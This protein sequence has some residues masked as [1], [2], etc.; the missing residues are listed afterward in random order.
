MDGENDKDTRIP[1]D[2]LVSLFERLPGEEDVHIDDFALV[3]MRVREL[4]EAATKWQDEISRTTMLSN[5]GG[6]RRAP[7][8]I[9]GKVDQEIESSSKLQIE[10]MK[11]LAANPILSKVVMPRE[12]AVNGI[13]RT[14][15]EFESK[16][17]A[18]LSMDF[19]GPYPDRAAYPNSH[20]LVGRT[21]EFIL[22]R[23]TMGELFESVLESVNE[24]SSI[25]ENV[26]AET[27]E[28]VTFEWIKRAVSWIEQ[29]N[30]SVTD[31]SPFNA[32]D[33]KALVIPEEIG[34]V[35]LQSA[36][37]IF[38]D[39]PDDLK[40][41]LS[42]HGIFVS[43]NKQD[44]NLRVVLKKDGAHHSVGG[45]VIRWC[46]ILFECLRADLTRL[47]HFRKE[48]EV[49]FQQFTAFYSRVKDEPKDKEENLYKWFCY[50]ERASAL[51]D[52]GARSLVV[53]PKKTF[54]DAFNNLRTTFRRILDTHS[55][56]ELEKKFA[57][58]WFMEG[59][60]LLDDRF[61]L[62]ES[63]LHRKSIA[64]DQ[65]ATDL[66]PDDASPTFRDIC[67]SYLV[68]SLTEA[69]KS[70]GMTGLTEEFDPI[71]LET[72]CSMKAWEI[73]G[74]MYIK[75]QDEIGV[76]RVSEDYRSK[77][78]NLKAS[79]SDKNNIS[80][81]LRILLG[82]IS[83]TDLVKM[84][85][86]ELASQ[87]TKL[88]RARA[89][90]EFRSA[91]NLTPGIGT[92][93]LQI[94]DTDEKSDDIPNDKSSSSGKP[95]SILRHSKAGLQPGAMESWANNTLGPTDNHTPTNAA[96]M[97]VKVAQSSEK[98]LVTENSLNR[99]PDDLL[100]RLAKPRSV[101]PP[102][103]PSLVTAFQ[104]S[105]NED[106]ED[107]T[108]N[109]HQIINESGGIEFHFESA[110]LRVSFDF[111]LYL[112]NG[113]YSTIDRFLQSSL[114][115]KGRVPGKEFAKFVSQKTSGSWIAIPLR[116]KPISD[117][118]DREIF[119]LCQAYEAKDRV[120][121]ISLNTDGN[122]KLFFVIPHFHGAASKTGGVSFS[123]KTSSYVLVLTKDTRFEG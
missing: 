100:K 28:K 49:I 62:L 34:R 65:I 88:E 32:A 123:S 93:S 42:Q 67:R 96:S 5:R 22:F 77:A 105:N 12:G 90:K 21:G 2:V 69:L 116:V 4:H 25:A 91:A 118:D 95:A 1:L 61:L 79:L 72:L 59:T 103:P 58:M 98:E 68:A 48:L 94:V 75:F 78:R 51:L 107:D 74:E 83:S 27:P 119:R 53:A 120:P 121:M 35:L 106:S 81:C 31:D 92:Q 9:S 16:L 99:P 52:D 20:S 112:E 44:Q 104:Q 46:P 24:L 7:I 37:S 43:T 63:L 40:K 23:L 111:N 102:P 87:R 41:T 11:Q 101:P 47:D 114:T 85:K 15:E 110:H 50:H 55:T 60:S 73:E 3:S 97:E 70:I 89:E 82:D 109:G 108:D 117:K 6:K 84:S 86:N 36:R 57:K 80:L 113:T 8:N 13:L 19:D 115:E 76:T 122:T 66:L 14:S 17:H 71:L 56:P 30:D 10:K 64:A 38:L 45:T 26:H 54:V 39:V 29:L 18:F 33:K